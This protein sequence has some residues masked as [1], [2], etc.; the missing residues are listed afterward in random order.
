MTSEERRSARRARRDAKR[1]ENRR[2]RA[3]GCTIEAVADLDN[4][5]EAARLASRG[6]RWKASVQRYM[7]RCLANC[8][9]SRRDLLAGRDIRMGFTRFDVFERG[10]LRHISACRFPERVIQKSIARNALAPAIWPTLTPG[11][12]ANIKGRG[13]DYARRRLKRQLASNA[14]AHGDERWV[15]LVDFSDYFG[16]IDHDA[17]RSLVRSAIDDPR[18]V[19][20]M[21]EQIDACGARGLGLGSETSQVLA[22]ALPS[23]IDRM[24][25]ATPGI[26][27]SGRYMDDTYAISTS[28]ETLRGALARTYELCEMLGI[29]VNP[30]KTRIV[31]LS[32][33]FSFLKRRWSIDGRRVVERPAPEAMARE[34]RKLKRQARLVEAGAM[35]AEQMRRSYASWRA[36]VSRCRS[37]RSLRS[38]DAL[39]KSLTRKE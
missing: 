21:D 16:H 22:V 20:L 11:C 13:V 26:E 6:I 8:A 38:M 17:A 4:L 32:R 33:E 9:K 5:F 2:R 24:L 35:S 31:K 37:H 7:A 18:I 10:K 39:Y 14:R 3:S 36:S 28:K 23:P 12:S 19:R 29:V 34:R 30:R 27:A 25:E 1:A 15:L